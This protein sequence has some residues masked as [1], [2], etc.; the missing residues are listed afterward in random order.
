MAINLVNN[1]ST[2]PLGIPNTGTGT[3]QGDTWDAAVL[4]M[5]AMFQELYTRTGGNAT[6]TSGSGAFPK[7]LIDCGDF[8]TNPFQRGVSFN[9]IAAITYTADRWFAVGLA[10]ATYSILV[11]TAV[12]T[13][14]QGFSTALQFGRANADTHA[15]QIFLGQVLET[16]DS[17]RVQGQPVTLS[18]YIAQGANFTTGSNT[19]GGGGINVQVIQGTGS[20][21]AALS[22]VAGSWTTQSNVINAS[23]SGFSTSA[24]ARLTFSGTVNSNTTQ[25]G[26]LFSYVGSGT[27]GSTEYVLLEGIQLEIGQQATSYEHKDI[28]IDLEIAQRYYYQITEPGAGVIVATG[29]AY[30][31][32]GGL[33]YTALPVQMRTAPTVTFVAGTFKM[34]TAATIGGVTT[35]GATAGATHTA[36]YIS[37]AASGTVISGQGVMLIGGGGSGYIGVS[38]EY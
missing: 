1:N 27:A 5:N 23:A 20:D 21:Q 12:T 10:S 24:Y 30:T 29:F 17:Y 16:K 22:M 9:S 8:T 26:V 33:F 4:K 36:N 34:A 28:Q 35:T 19:G 37:L 18:F 25:L 31:I 38:S 32:N 3:D 6:L 7:N 11:Q 15:T 13:T 14:N 2:Q